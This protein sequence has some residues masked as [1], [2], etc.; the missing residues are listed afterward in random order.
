[1]LKWRDEITIVH[2]FA[3]ELRP[4][5]LD[6][7]GLVPALHAHMKKFMADT[8]I[9]A[10]LQVFAGIEKSPAPV[11]TMLYRVAQ[12]A[13]TNV[14][15]HARASQVGV[16]IEK[17][18]GGVRMEI[19]DNGKGFI[20]SRTTG[21]KPSTRLGLIGMKERVE[22]IGGT[23]HVESAPGQPTTIRIEIKSPAKKSA[24]TPPLPPS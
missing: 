7:L 1:M 11:R 23:F 6:D 15:R 4:T 24:R 8:G 5:V 21:A 10:S 2:Q 16:N 12:E 18:K 13:L 20:V 17:I 3:L 9:R 19:T 14:A 22:M